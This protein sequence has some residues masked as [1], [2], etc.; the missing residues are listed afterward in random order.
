MASPDYTINFYFLRKL[1]KEEKK[2]NKMEKIN[3][4]ELLIYF[5]IGKKCQQMLIKK[6]R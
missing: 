4:G 2:P 1:K 3:H 6:K 5:D